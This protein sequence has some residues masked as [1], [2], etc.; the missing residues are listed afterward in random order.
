MQSHM[1][2]R[3]SGIYAVRIVVPHRLRPFVGR[4]EVHASTGLRERNTA[5]LAA[6]QILLAWRQRFMELDRSKLEVTHPVLL[7]DGM[8]T[9]RDAAMIIGTPLPALLC[10]LLN[11]RTPLYVQLQGWQGW[12]VPD[13]DT[14]DRDE[15]GAFIMNAVE[16]YGEQRILSGVMARPYDTASIIGGLIAGATTSVSL[17]MISNKAAFFLAEVQQ[18]STSSLFAQKPAIERIRAR[19]A[20]LLPPAPE[21]PAI[22]HGNPVA[23]DGPIIFD[24]ITAKHGKK[25]FSQLFEVYRND[26]NWKEDHANRMA[27]EAR[28]FC[29]LMDDP[30]LA[31]IE[32]E[33]IQEYGRRLA[34]MPSDVY[35]A[36]RKFGVET[37]EEL[38]HLARQHNLELK[39]EDTIKRHVGYISEILNYGVKKHIVRFNP[40]SDFKRGRK[41]DNKGSPQADRERFTPE[42]LA[43]IFT[44]DWF[45]KGS[46]GK[47]NAKHWRS[48][49]YWLPIMGLLTGGRINELSQLYLDDVVQS[50]SGTWYFD[51][52]LNQPDKID[53]DAQADDKSLKTVNAIRVVPL[54]GALVALG[55]PEYVAALK[56]AGYSRLF[57]ELRHDRLKGYGKPSGSWFNE[58][59]LGKKLGIERNG[60]KVFHSFRHNFVTALERLEVSEGV[61]AQLAGHQR[62]KTESGTR[63][64]KDRSADELKP[65]FDRLDFPVL[66]G[67]AP[68]N[69]A[70][71]LKSVKYALALKKRNRKRALSV[72]KPKV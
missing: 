65:L 61:R 21:K 35:Q 26:R 39:Q 2:R 52:N 60:K 69:I 14:I 32:A 67:I 33:T 50:E 55:L 10:E 51:F 27:N 31:E 36:R 47:G 5:K 7:T 66:A 18:V 25:R 16:A 19:L 11:D 1:Y 37:A 56:K 13:L 12:W 8:I 68:F 58:R 49:N 48:Y 20:A 53:A 57:P 17:L 46:S 62:G 43:L 6:L 28:L 70:E 59:F 38:I 41:F 9:L 22:T 24:P 63:Y 30:E 42:E 3:P 54:H 29:E 23:S 45:P 64:S 72:S 44:H 34:Q 4:T 40:A 15:A 71:G